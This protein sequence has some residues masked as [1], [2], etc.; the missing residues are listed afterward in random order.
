[1]ISLKKTKDSSS[2]NVIWPHWLFFNFTSS[3]IKPSLP[4]H[5]L[6]TVSLTGAG[7]FVLSLFGL[8]LVLLPLFLWH[9]GRPVLPF[10]TWGPIVPSLAP[11]PW[12]HLVTQEE[13][14][15]LTNIL[16]DCFP[17]HEYG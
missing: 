17:E 16:G 10:H 2:F 15:D 14:S 3:F 6:C 12:R 9:W 7:S 11:E 8:H 4:T 13:R 1:M 5:N